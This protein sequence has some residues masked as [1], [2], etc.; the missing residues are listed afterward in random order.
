M[1]IALPEIEYQTAIPEAARAGGRQAG[2]NPYLKYMQGMPLP[3]MTTPKKGQPAVKQYASFFMV[4]DPVSE[5]IT[6]EAEKAKAAK[7]N[8]DKLIN[9]FTSLARRINKI[10]PTANFIFRKATNEAGAAGIRVFRGDAKMASP[11]PTSAPAS[12]A[13]TG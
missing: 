11:A 12:V 8:V 9:R 2:E 10:D 13:A 1:T 7:A 4:A 6:D 5:T 3:T